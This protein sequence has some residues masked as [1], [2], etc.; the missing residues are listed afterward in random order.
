MRFSNSPV[1]SVNGNSDTRYSCTLT[2]NCQVIAQF[3][4]GHNVLIRKDIIGKTPRQH[5]EIR[6]RRA[7]GK[8]NP[9]LPRA[10]CI[11]EM[12][13]QSTEGFSIWDHCTLDEETLG[14]RRELLGGQNIPA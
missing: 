14:E 9:G 12:L 4:K 6:S 5:V 2:D 7:A 8:R 1:L 3:T 13:R 10:S 11:D